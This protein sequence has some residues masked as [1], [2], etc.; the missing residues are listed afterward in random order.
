[1]PAP[2]SNTFVLVETTLSAASENEAQEFVEAVVR[3]RLA[4]CGNL[5]GPVESVYHWKGAIER[6]KEFVASFKTTRA[7]ARALTAWIQRNHP[8]DTPYVAV[9]PMRIAHGGY[10]AWLR[11]ETRLPPAGSTKPR[12]APRPASKSR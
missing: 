6:Q 8:Y 10:A 11:Q 2:G 4:A 7:R 9:L 1:M 12:R 3:Q 5:H